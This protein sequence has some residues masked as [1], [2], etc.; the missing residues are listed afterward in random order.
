MVQVEKGNSM[1]VFCGAGKAGR[2]YL[3]MWRKC[4]LQVDYFADNNPELWGKKVEDVDVISMED[5]K[6][7]PPNANYYITCKSVDVMRE[8]LISLGIPQ[9]SIRDCSIT[10][11]MYGY[12]MQQPGFIMPISVDES[13]W[14]KCPAQVLFDFQNGMVLGGVESWSAQTAHKLKNLGWESC[15]LISGTQPDAIEK[16]IS[17]WNVG[18]LIHVEFENTITEQETFACLSNGIAKSGCRNIIINFPGYHLVAACLVKRAV[19]D[20]VKVI[21]VVH[22]DEAVYYTYYKM[23]ENYI[24]Q[25]LVIS[26]RIRDKMIKNGFPQAKLEYLPWEIACEEQFYH[27]YTSKYGHLRIGYAGR[28]ETQQ[29]RMDYLVEVVK[30]LKERR[31]D[32]KLEIA[33]NGSYKEQLAKEI[34]KNQL[35]REVQILGV[36]DA[37][38]IR[39][40][41]KRQDIMVSCSDWE[42]HSISQG[43]AMAAGAVPVVTDVS[44][45]SDDITDGENGFIVEVGSVEQITEKIAYFYE[46]RELLPVM[47]EKA[48]QTILINNNGKKLENLW[49]NLLLE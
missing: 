20:K 44:G 46:H 7:L 17:F 3:C 11:N 43:E 4:G 22:N 2:K 9:T 1:N 24:D 42:G 23:F 25:C 10:M 16:N 45:A 38:E 37:A 29:K 8:Q 19:P 40:F 28:I 41:W 21:A 27:T 39:E 6:K 49:R 14:E 15:F 48:H 5:L 36:L 33:G 18:K 13:I 31:I 34:S 35:D 47:G 12:A 32:F 30:R 26:E